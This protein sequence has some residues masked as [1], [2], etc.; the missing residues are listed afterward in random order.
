MT[1]EGQMAW[2]EILCETN[3]TPG[4]VR[5]LQQ[6]LANEGLNPGPI[7]GVVGGATLNA[8]RAYQ[9]KKGLPTGGVTMATLKS[10]GVL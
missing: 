9:T 6:A 7:D 5:K 1:T 3:T 2:R 10:L 4:L 8:V